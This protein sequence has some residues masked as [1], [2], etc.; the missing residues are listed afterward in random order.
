[1]SKRTAQL[2]AIA[3]NAIKT[4]NVHLNGGKSPDIVVIVAEPG[5]D[6]LD[7]MS[8]VG[9]ERTTWLLREADIEGTD[10]GE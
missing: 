10:I 2:A 5:T 4:A 1:M 8:N 7:M 3:I 6:D 9:A